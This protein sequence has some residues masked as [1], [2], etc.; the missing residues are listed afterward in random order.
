MKILLVDVD[1]KIPNLALMKLST[2]HKQL[3]DSVEIIKL[4]LPGYPHNRKFK[5]VDAKGFDKVYVSSVFT[6]NQGKYKI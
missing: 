3:G 5:S 6:V 1:S 4:G 2:Y